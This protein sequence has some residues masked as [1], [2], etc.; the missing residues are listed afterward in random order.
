MTITHRLSLPAL[1]VILIAS[2]IAAVTFGPAD[3]TPG[4]VWSVIA[5]H[6]GILPESPVSRLRD[7]IVWELRLPRVLTALGVGAGLALSGAVMQALT[8]NPLADPFLLGLS[9]GAALGAV[10][11][12]LLGLTLLMPLGAFFG[13]LGALALALLIAQLLGGATPSRAI[14]AGI[15]IAA[16]ASAA[17][18]FLIFWSAT[19]DSYREILSWLMGSLSGSIWS[20]AG[21]VYLALAACLPIILA[22]GRALDAFAF[23]DTAAAS[24]G[25]DVPRLRWTLLGATALLTG[26]MVAIGG[27]IGFVGLVVPHAVRLAVGSAH[28]KLLPHVMLAG[29]IFMLWTDTAAR[30]LFDPRELPVGI[31]TAL[32]GAPVF[33]AVLLRYRRIT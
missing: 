32:I 26:I 13:S 20:D 1:A 33:L 9:S 2:A 29:A 11:F 17:T 8:R 7:A 25:I 21:L 22:N 31:I 4:E 16:L 18:S 12:L 5:H 27:A 6:L 15:C 23:G 14:L 10:S 3:I 24:L 19:G 28:R 30:T